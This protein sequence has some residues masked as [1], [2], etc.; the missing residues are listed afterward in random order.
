[1]PSGHSQSSLFSTVFI[2]FSLQNKNISFLYLTVSAITML[3]RVLNQHH[4]ILQ[5][6]VDRVIFL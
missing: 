2:Y 1:M 3:Q 5:A 4:T 6:C